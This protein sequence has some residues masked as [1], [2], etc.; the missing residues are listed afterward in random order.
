[1]RCT[2]ESA[3]AQLP[4]RRRLAQMIMV[5]VDARGPQ[6]ALAVVTSEQVGGIFLAGSATGLLSDNA[7]Q[8]V[9]YTAALP[10]AVGVAGGVAVAVGVA[11]AGG[12]AVGVAVM[13]GVG[14]TAAVPLSVKVFPASGTKR[15]E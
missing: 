6:Q 1:M 13:G 7:L 8:Q 3:I 14:T 9:Q 15:Q 12:V 4:I 2:Q 5:G 11:V 10:V